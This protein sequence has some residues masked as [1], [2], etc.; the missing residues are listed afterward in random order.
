MIYPDKTVMVVANSIFVSLAERLARDFGKTYLCV[1][2]AG[3]F[4]TPN[5][6]LVGYGLKG[7]ERVDDVFG[8]HFDSVDL[9]VFVDLYKSALQIHLEK[10]GKRVWGNR[11]AE[12]LECHRALC[13]EEMVK[14]GLTVQPYAVVTG[15]D[16]LR[17][18]LKSHKDQHVKIDRWR[19]L[20]ETFFAPTYE[21]VEGKIDKIAADLGGF[22]DTLNFICEDDLP[23]MVEVGVDTYTIDGQY[24]DA[25][26]FGIEAKDCGYV[27]QMV[28]WGEIPEPLR[29]WNEAFAPLFSR[30]GARGS[31]SNEIRIDDRIDPVMVD[32]TIRAPCPPSELW[33]ELFTNLPEI[34]WEGAAGNLVEPV[35]AGRWGVEVII[36]SDWAENNWQEVSYPTEYANQIK[37]FNAVEIDGRR[38]VVPQDDQMA[39]IGAVVGW[40][41][42][43]EAAMEHAKAAGESI[44]GYGVKFEMGSIDK[45]TDQIAELDKIGMSPFTLDKQAA[46]T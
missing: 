10:L 37:L 33:Q 43:L 1:P 45:I 25:T 21:I 13:K 39:E 44:K 28:R 12:E 31:I 40:G 3:S 27:G 23:D 4:P 35:P 11:N 42:T 36:K 9:F 20:T 18:H 2:C 8:P 32:A 19:G 34:M 26:L 38:Y 41:D 7:V 16:A 14:A 22:K 30:Y 46:K 24:P 29:R 17:A 6:G 15:V 5:H